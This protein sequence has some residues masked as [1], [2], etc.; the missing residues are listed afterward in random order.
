MI[1]STYHENWMIQGS[2]TVGGGESN[3]WACYVD[4]SPVLLVHHCWPCGV[5]HLTGQLGSLA[6]T[7]GLAERVSTNP[8]LMALFGDYS[9]VMVHY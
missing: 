8:K 3:P 1:D 9:K 2:V 5:H 6:E 7:V 4:P